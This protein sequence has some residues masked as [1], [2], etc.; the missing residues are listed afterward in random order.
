MG[1]PVEIQGVC[2]DRFMAVH[3]AF[4][5]NFTDGHELGAR[6]AA[7]IDGEIVIDL[8]GGWSD[9]AMT[10]PF[11][12][13]T[14]APVFSTTK[15]VAAVMIGRL[16]GQGLADYGQPVSDLWPEFGAA[17]KANV[18]L[19]QCLSHQDGLAAFPGRMDPA[20]WLDRDAICARLAAMTPLWPPGSAS[21]Y[22]PLTSGY[23]AG[24]IFRRADGRPMAQAL[25]DD[26][27]T[28][29]DLDLW[30][31]LPDAEVD[32]VA[33]MQRPPAAPDLGPI[34]PLK[35]AAF[36]EPWSSPPG[37]E[38][39]AWRRAEVPS[40]NGYATAPALARLMAAIACDGALDGRQVL[41]P[42][43][44][45]L[46]MRQRIVGPD[47]VLPFTLSWGAGLLRN[48]PNFIYGP[49]PQTAGHSGW[50]GSCVMADPDRRLS[51]AYVM[52]RQSIYLIGDPRPMRLLEALYASF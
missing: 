11:A 24:E 2:P 49:G 43:V 12:P 47:L 46:L 48:A 23:I 39:T 33:Q 20:L 31:G 40:A 13:D 45:A 30:I 42:G 32:R 4:E 51:A 29:L 16:V 17:G 21:G 25:R 18:T 22:H 15:A 37:R 35:R 50:G 26:L 5:A 3:Q 28:P 7:A 19:E 14:L 44:A 36:L 38:T 10:R 6:F 8:M 9:R 27:A 41:E 52:N 34:T 1:G